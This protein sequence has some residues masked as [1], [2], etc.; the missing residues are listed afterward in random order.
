MNSGIFPKS[1]ISQKIFSFAYLQLCT[2]FITNHS[3]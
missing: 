2:V 1:M 3:S